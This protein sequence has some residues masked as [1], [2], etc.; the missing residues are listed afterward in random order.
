MTL[1]DDPVK[2]F[3]LQL[4]AHKHRRENKLDQTRLPLRVSINCKSLYKT[5]PGMQN[6][7]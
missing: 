6:G 7:Y 2:C 1:T 3:Y 5:T 4:S